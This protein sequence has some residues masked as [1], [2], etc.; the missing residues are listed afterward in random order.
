MTRKG[1]EAVEP[2]P[3]TSEPREAPA[4]RAAAKEVAK[5]LLDEAGQP[6]AVAQGGRLRTKH[7]EVIAHHLIQNAARGLPRLIRRRR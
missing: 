1:H 6:L 2:T 3:R 5:L 4:E 7:L